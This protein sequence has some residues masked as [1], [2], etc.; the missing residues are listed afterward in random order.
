MPAPEQLPLF[1]ELPKAV[2]AVVLLRELQPDVTL[3]TLLVGA[4]AWHY[5]LKRAKRRSIGLFVDEEGLL[6]VAPR[7]VSIAD[8]ES[9]IRARRDWIEKKRN[10]M[11]ERQ[12]LI[13]ARRIEW[14]EGGMLPFLGETLTLRLK[15]EVVSP[16]LDAQS[17]ELHLPLLS[18][19]V[20]TKLRELVQGWCQRQA[21]RI[22]HARVLHFAQALGVAVKQVRLSSATSRWGMANANGSILLN[23]RLIHFPAPVIDYVVAHEVAHLREMNHSPRFW[24]LVESVYPDHRQARDFLRREVVALF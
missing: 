5:R 13:T 8:I 16:M 21:L 7:W 17:G 2:D 20:P 11:A 4:Q 19:D 23:W 18:E 10:E 15:R 12:K 24:K 22:F 1:D 9:A 3:R 6:I 14:R